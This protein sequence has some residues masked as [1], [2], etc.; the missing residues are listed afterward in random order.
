MSQQSNGARIASQKASSIASSPAGVM[1]DADRRDPAAVENAL[2]AQLDEFTLA[3]GASR[4][5]HPHLD[6]H[7]AF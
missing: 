1:A 7:P 5:R 6:R 3:D 4:A 2:N